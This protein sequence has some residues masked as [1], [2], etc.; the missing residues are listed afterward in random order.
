M[1]Q[2][3]DKQQPDY[4]PYHYDPNLL[5]C[6]ANLD[7]INNK[8][9]EQ[10]V[11]I[12][13]VI[14]PIL[15]LNSS[16]ILIILATLIYD[17]RLNSRK[18]SQSKISDHEDSEFNFLS[19]NHIA[20]SRRNLNKIRKSSIVLII[21]F[22]IFMIPFYISRINL[23]AINSKLIL[24]L[25][26]LSVS[27][28][29]ILF[30]YMNKTTRVSIK[31]CLQYFVQ[32]P[33]YFGQ[34]QDSE[35][36]SI[37]GWVAPEPQRVRYQETS[38]SRHLNFSQ[39]KR[40]EMPDSSELSDIFL[41]AESPEGHRVLIFKKMGEVVKLPTETSLVTL[42][43]T[44][45][46]DEEVLTAIIETPP[47]NSGPRTRIPAVRISKVASQDTNEDSSSIDDR[48]KYIRR[49]N[50]SVPLAL[51]DEYERYS[52]VSVEEKPI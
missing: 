15:T 18:L 3:E 51:Q 7:E 9:T 31:K 34:R 26:G 1:L 39:L 19:S 20:Q 21:F 35:T 16:F 22:D 37:G 52:C 6:A 38:L 2:P 40:V 42:A 45:E 36:R 41:R 44:I 17:R 47:V 13:A 12:V 24:I 11:K 4:K 48:E 8:T 5:N 33:K 27:I 29:P 23:I 46:N 14:L 25:Y 49:K 50:F 43:T 32:D 30:G 28:S 10:S